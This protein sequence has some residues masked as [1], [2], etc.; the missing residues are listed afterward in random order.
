M[1]VHAQLAPVRQMTVKEFLRF[2]ATRPDGEKW[3][4]IEGVAVMN[5]T[6][7]QLHQLIVGNIVSYLGAHKQVTGAAWVPMIGVGTYVPVSPNSLPEPDVYVQEGPVLLTPTTNDALV[8]FEVL[9]RSNTK[10]D[11]EWRR[12]VY[13]SVP[14]CQHYVA[15]SLK[16]ADVTVYSRE[17]GWAGARFTGVK[18][19]VELPGIGV[20]MP[21][22]EVYRWTP[23]GIAKPAVPKKR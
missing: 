4:L 20:S 5:A 15:V 11:Q 23:I 7:V 2:Y 19:N 8:I 9:S 13:S 17:A 21:L 14:N 3:E 10:A 12:H 18:S 16:A 6:P 22:A 1:N